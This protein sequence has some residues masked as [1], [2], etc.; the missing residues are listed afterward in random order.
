MHANKVLS[1]W[2]GD[3][4]S[5]TTTKDSLLSTAAFGPHPPTGQPFRTHLE[6]TGQSTM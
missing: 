2:L 5:T 1:S 3:C 4:L 6:M